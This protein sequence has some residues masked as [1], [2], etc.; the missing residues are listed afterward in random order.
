[1]HLKRLGPGDEEEVLNAPHLLDEPADP[2]VVRNYLA[3]DRN[4]FLLA[5][6]DDHAVGFLRGTALSQLKSDRKQMFLYEIGV[7]LPFRRRGVG[8]ELVRW[9]IE[10]SRSGGF[11]EIFVFTDP[12]NDAAVNLYRST[13]AVTETSADRMYVYQLDSMGDGPDPADP[14]NR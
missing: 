12:S 7:D 11:E 9:L 4:V 14:F 8:S 1:M 5:I 10:H 2:T 6:E 13:G 3:D